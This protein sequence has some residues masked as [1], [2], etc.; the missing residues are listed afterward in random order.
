LSKRLVYKAAI[1]E[2]TYQEER[3][4]LDQQIAFAELEHLEARED[5]L[6]VQGALTFSEHVLSNAGRLWVESD[7]SGKQRLQQAL[8]SQGVTF[9]NHSIATPVTSSIFYAIEDA[10]GP[11]GKFWLP[12]R[13][14]NPDMLIQSQL[15]CR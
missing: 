1:D 5:E 3:H 9:D 8:F 15:S 12:P 10:V 6:D 14:S 11:T 13:D 2:S 4:N 7:L